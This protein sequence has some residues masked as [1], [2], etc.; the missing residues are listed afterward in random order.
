MKL[1]KYVKTNT[2]IQKNWTFFN[3]IIKISND[4][5]EIKNPTQKCHFLE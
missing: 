1:K 2:T 4:F 5:F 3:R